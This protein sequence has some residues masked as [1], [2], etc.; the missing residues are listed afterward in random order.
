M[1]IGTK[2]CAARSGIIVE[3]EDSYNASK[4]TIERSSYKVN[5]VKIQHSDNTI[6][7]YAHLRKASITFNKGQKIAEGDCFAQSGNSGYSTGPHL[8]FSVL[9]KY[10]KKEQSV[11]FIFKQPENKSVVPQYLAWLYN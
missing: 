8:H 1:P 11:P 4:E 5:Y 3:L 10:G 6:G 9:K 7:L 2:V